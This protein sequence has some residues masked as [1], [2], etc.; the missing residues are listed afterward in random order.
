MRC[1]NILL[2]LSFFL[3]LPIMT[4]KDRTH[5]AENHPADPSTLFSSVLINA[6]VATSRSWRSTPGR[7]LSRLLPSWLGV[8]LQ[9]NPFPSLCCSTPSRRIPKRGLQVKN[10]KKPSGPRNQRRRR[11]RPTN[12]VGIREPTMGSDPNIPGTGKVERIVTDGR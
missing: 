12:V 4:S 6:S 2:S 3:A 5:S 10:R 8:E 9:R 11:I 1:V 7:I